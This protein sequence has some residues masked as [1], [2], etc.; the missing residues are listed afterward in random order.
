MQ[1]QSTQVNILV[2]KVSFLTTT[3][4]ETIDIIYGETEVHSLTSPVYKYC[5]TRL[6]ADREHRSPIGTTRGILFLV[7][8]SK[9]ILSF[10]YFAVLAIKMKE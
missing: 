4:S 9:H 6:R 2:I 10:Q 5:D 3:L 7:S 8:R 1:L